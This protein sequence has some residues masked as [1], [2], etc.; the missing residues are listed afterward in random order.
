MTPTVC[1]LGPVCTAKQQ[2]AGLPPLL[3]AGGR[4]VGIEKLWGSS[5]RICQVI[6]TSPAPRHRQRVEQ[7][8]QRML[9]VRRCAVVPR[10]ELNA[11]LDGGAAAAASFWLR[12]VPTACCQAA[13]PGLCS[14]ARRR[15]DSSAERP[16]A[17]RRPG[18][19]SG[20]AGAG[21]SAR[22]RQGP[23]QVCGPAACAGRQ[24]P[25]PC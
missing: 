5:D 12:D 4:P 14:S 3:T 9:L 17:G 1:T 10:R 13:P 25:D 16:A 22:S 6:C 7:S 15:S 18:V 24:P 21:E 2:K 20:G 23:R 11:W 19:Q 8:L